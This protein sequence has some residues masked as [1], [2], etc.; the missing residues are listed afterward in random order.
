MYNSKIKCIKSVIDCSQD[1]RTK[2]AHK[3]ECDINQVLKKYLKT[4]LIDHVS[5]H[6][7]QYGEAPGIDFKEALDLVRRSQD[8]FDDLPA[9]ARKHFNND[10]AAFMDAVHEEGNESLMYELGLS[11][12]PP[13][14]VLDEP[15]SD[16]NAP[17]SPASATSSGSSSSKRAPA[18]ETEV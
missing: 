14:P 4:G 6:N 10:P 13:S 9:K 2:Q 18:A 11:D 1:G 8:M 12:F 5:S 3:D 17:A 16:P 15:V 7:G